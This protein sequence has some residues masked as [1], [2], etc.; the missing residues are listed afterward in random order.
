MKLLSRFIDQYNQCVLS[1]I[2][3]VRRDFATLVTNIA[4]NT[5]TLINIRLS[6]SYP[7]IHPDAIITNTC[8][9]MA[10]HSDNQLEVQRS[11]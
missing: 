6:Y 4:L 9:R 2:F 7:L 11:T 5:I 8:M 3:R 10:H 1:S